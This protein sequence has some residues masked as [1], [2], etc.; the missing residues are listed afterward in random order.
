MT[1]KVRWADMTGR[2]RAAAVVVAGVQFGLLA[3]ALVDIAR[4]DPAEINGSKLRWA[5][6][7]LVNFV[8]PVLYFARGRRRAS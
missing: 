1:R 6:I 2:Q 8:G 4:R 7:C 3:A 5:L